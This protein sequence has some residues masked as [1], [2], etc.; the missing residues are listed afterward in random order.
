MI[1]EIEINLGRRK[2][3][4]ALTDELTWTCDEAAVE[5]FLNAT[6]SEISHQRSMPCPPVYYLY[7]AGQRLGGLVR[8]HRHVDAVA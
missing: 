8:P 4:A 5:A 6:F 1:G 3:V 2:V 7:Q